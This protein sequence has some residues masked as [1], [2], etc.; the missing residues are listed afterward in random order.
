MPWWAGVILLAAGLLAW[1]YTR[2]KK[3]HPGALDHWG[4]ITEGRIKPSD[5]RRQR[6]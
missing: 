3:K 5:S 6:G 4:A 1:L 2:L